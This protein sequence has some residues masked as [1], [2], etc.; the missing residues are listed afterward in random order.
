MM[1]DHFAIDDIKVIDRHPANNDKQALYA[2]FPKHI[3]VCPNYVPFPPLCQTREAL[4]TREL[5]YA[6][7]EVILRGL[8]IEKEAIRREKI[9][10]FATVTDS[11]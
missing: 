6:C 10:L 4:L 5:R 7:V 11:Q 2:E 1:A 9:R 3:D 8:S